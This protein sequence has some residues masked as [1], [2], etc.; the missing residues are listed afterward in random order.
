MWKLVQ[1]TPNESL[2]NLRIS[3]A[4]YKVLLTKSPLNEMLS[5]G[6]ELWI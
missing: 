2:L 4:K 5:L 6:T 1:D 3:E